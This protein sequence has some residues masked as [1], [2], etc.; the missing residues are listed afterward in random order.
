MP[1]KIQKKYVKEWKLKMQSDFDFK[2]NTL[3]YN[4]CQCRQK[5]KSQIIKSKIY[6]AGITQNKQI[7]CF[8]F[9]WSLKYM[10]VRYY[11]KVSH[12]N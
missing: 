6:M 1:I 2:K 11:T 8:H 4:Y 3:V 12:N 9:V 5:F 10:M 7:P